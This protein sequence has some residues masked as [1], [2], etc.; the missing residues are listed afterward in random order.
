[1]VKKRHPEFLFFQVSQ[2]PL[3]P[4]VVTIE[5]ETKQP[6]RW[7]QV[8][9]FSYSDDGWFVC[10]LFCLPSFSIC[11]PVCGQISNYSSF[12]SLFVCLFVEQQESELFE[13]RRKSNA[14]NPRVI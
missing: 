8:C 4:E 12:A 3:I 9:K 14:I 7:S 10:L 5:G 1:M 2:A 11:F 13:T 6:R